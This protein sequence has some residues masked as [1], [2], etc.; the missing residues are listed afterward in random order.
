MA[1]PCQ[2]HR[3]CRE[4][5]VTVYLSYPPYAQPYFEESEKAIQQINLALIERIEIPILN[6]PE[7]FVYHERYF[8]D[9]AYHLNQEMGAARSQAI[10]SAIQQRHD[11]GDLV[12]LESQSGY[13]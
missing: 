12:A 2:F 4:R 10:A 1:R 7:T 3:A 13:R 9:S 8:F 5:G 11:Q 6:Q